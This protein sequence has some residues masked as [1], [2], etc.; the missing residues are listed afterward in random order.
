MSRSWDDRR[1]EAVTRGL[2]LCHKCVKSSGG[3][4][5]IRVATFTLYGMRA[6]LLSL[7]AVAGRALTVAAAHP[8]GAQAASGVEYGL[9]DDAWLT[10]GPGTLES[11]LDKLQ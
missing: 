10:D 4:V 8:A 7:L 11:R 2:R 6:R 1:V 3:K 9:T 5:W